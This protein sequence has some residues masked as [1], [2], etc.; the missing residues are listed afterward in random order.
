MRRRSG[1]R[2]KGKVGFILIVFLIV[3]SIYSFLAVDR[4]LMPTVLA[5]SEVKAS[6]TQ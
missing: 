6:V 3:A 2:H 5:F 1:R 4:K